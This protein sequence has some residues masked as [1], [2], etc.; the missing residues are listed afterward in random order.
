MTNDQPCRPLTVSVSLLHI[1]GF[2]VA[3]IE[4]ILSL[5]R[6]RVDHKTFP[7]FKIAKLFMF[8]RVYYFWVY[9]CLLIQ[10]IVLV[11]VFP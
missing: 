11:R 8:G 2:I 10:L 6:L 7:I 1:G 3:R 9:L 5:L 4:E